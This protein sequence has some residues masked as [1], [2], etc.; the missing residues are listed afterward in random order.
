MMFATK[1][2]RRLAACWHCLSIVS[3]GCAEPKKTVDS[4]PAD[5]KATDAGTAAEPAASAPADMPVEEK[6]ASERPLRCA[7]RGRTSG[8]STCRERRPLPRPPRRQLLM[9]RRPM[10]SRPGQSHARL[11]RADRRNSGRGP[12]EPG[13]SRSLAGR[14]QE[15]RSCSTSSCRWALPPASAKSRARQESA[16]PGQDR[17]RP[18]TVFRPAAVVA[19]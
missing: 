7:A 19:T 6:V 10:R 16:H 5:A 11:A 8:C 17:A 9:R 15:P 13:R 4:K 18:A 12:A 1:I 14:S 2:L 3:L